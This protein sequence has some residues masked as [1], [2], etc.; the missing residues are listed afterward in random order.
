MGCGI[1]FPANLEEARQ[2]AQEENAAVGAAGAAN[3]GREG[4]RPGA[5]NQYALAQNAS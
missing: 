5:D 1:L 3:E 4:G 2:A